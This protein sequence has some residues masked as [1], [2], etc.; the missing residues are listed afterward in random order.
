MGGCAVMQMGA[1]ALTEF[2]LIQLVDEALG[3]NTGL[4]SSREVV[5]AAATVVEAHVDRLLDLYVESVIP[6]F[7]S[8]ETA[9]LEESQPQFHQSWALRR[10]WLRRG[11]AVDLA[12]SSE[13]GAFLLLVE[14]RNSLVHGGGSITQFQSKK[15][16]EQ[17]DLERR[18]RS[19]LDVTTTAKRIYLGPK[20]AT[21][22]IAIAHR[23]LE[24]LDAELAS[25]P[26]SVRTGGPR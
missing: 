14:L 18:F 17:L 26:N 1:S 24:R 10:Q 11:F 22:A 2:T 13:E 19:E 4:S 15:L 23:Y 5:I 25:A 6:T 8:F 12:G 21:R 7:S 9:L 16:S 3:R 20:T